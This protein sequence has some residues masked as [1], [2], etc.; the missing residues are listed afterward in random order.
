MM[1][2][3]GPLAHCVVFRFVAVY[4]KKGHRRDKA[5]SARADGKGWP[6]ARA[7][8][9]HVYAP[10]PEGMKLPRR[11]AL[12]FCPGAVRTGRPSLRA[13][14]LALGP[15]PIRR[16]AGAINRRGRPRAAQTDIVARF[17]FHGD[18][19][20]F[21]F[22]AGWA[23][24]FVGRKPPRAASKTHIG[25]T[26][27]R[28]VVRPRRRDRLLV[29]CFAAHHDGGDFSKNATPPTTQFLSFAG[30]NRAEW[31]GILPLPL[32]SGGTSSSSR[33]SGFPKLIAYAKA[34]PRQKNQHWHRRHPGT[35]FTHPAG[36]ED[37][38]S[39]GIL[40]A[41]STWFTCRL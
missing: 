10:A 26:R 15:T 8:P 37:S 28:P 2:A 11:Q 12:P 5:T 19:A 38:Y 7:I 4:A 39:R 18:V 41:P 33:P 29:R 31:P 35:G 34:K 32:H 1:T 6:Q 20:R 21:G 40:A 27:G 36:E 14:S 3:I 30:H 13:C 16:G 23:S 25:K 9:P 22:G 17:F 24:S